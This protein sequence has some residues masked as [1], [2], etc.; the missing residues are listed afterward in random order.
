M[1]LLCIR[2]T[3]TTPKKMQSV[4]SS[5]RGS[6]PRIHEYTKLLPWNTKRNDER[7]S[8]PSKEHLRTEQ[9][10]ILGTIMGYHAAVFTASK[11]KKFIETDAQYP[12]KDRIRRSYGEGDCWHY[13][14]G[15]SLKALGEQGFLEKCRKGRRTVYEVEN[16]K[17]LED[18]YYTLLWEP[19]I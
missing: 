8:S 3:S 2:E 15:R 12:M 7:S 19:R 13:P 17:K 10:K 11:I 18:F 5:K 14:L 9:L 4:S 1:A 16:W 6:W